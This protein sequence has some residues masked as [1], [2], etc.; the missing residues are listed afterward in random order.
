MV[1]EKAN[2]HET[3]LQSTKD[4]ILDDQTRAPSNFV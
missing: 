4:E 3:N 1:E 2:L